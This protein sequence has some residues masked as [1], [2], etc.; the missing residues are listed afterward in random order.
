MINSESEN[1]TLSEVNCTITDIKEEKYSLIC[2]INESLKGDFQSYFHYVNS[3]ID[4]TLLIMYIDLYNE[5]LTK[6]GNRYNVSKKNNGFALSITAIALTYIVCI[7]AFIATFII[8]REKNVKKQ[9]QDDLSTN[10]LNIKNKNI[11]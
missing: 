9:M 1:N 3:F 7:G 10:S 4:N 5:S 2:R 11:I 8:L 6:I